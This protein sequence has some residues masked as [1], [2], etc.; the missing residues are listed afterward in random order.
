VENYL[1]NVGKYHDDGEEALGPTIA[2]LSLG[3]T[4]KMTIR[5]K[6][7]HYMGWS[8]SSNKPWV[9]VPAL[10]MSKNFEIRNEMNRWLH[11]NPANDTAANR[12]IL[13][14]KLKTLTGK[15]QNAKDCISMRLNH[16]NIVIMHGARLQECFEVS[17]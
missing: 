4:A 17:S 6:Q 3:G 13:K 9:S 10:P 16:G 12:Q 14:E 1:T 7:S 11:H 5:L 8:N 2:T 15:A